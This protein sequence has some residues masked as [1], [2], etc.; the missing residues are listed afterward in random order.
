MLH[1]LFERF[2]FVSCLLSLDMMC[3]TGELQPW[4][5][6]QS[7]T[8]MNWWWVPISQEELHIFRGGRSA[9]ICSLAWLLVRDMF[10]VRPSVPIRWVVQ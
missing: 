5:F 8:R 10:F 6:H 1:S 9:T 2:V 7:V 3:I 4:R